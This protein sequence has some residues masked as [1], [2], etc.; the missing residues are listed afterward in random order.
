MWAGAA[1]ENPRV[2]LR[3]HSQEGTTYIV[4]GV[5]LKDGSAASIAEA[6][7]TQKP[8]VLS[9]LDAFGEAAKIEG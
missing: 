3:S 1:R 9:V 7:N 2:V 4:D 6:L 5:P 8:K